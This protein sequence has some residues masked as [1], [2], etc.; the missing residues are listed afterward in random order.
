[1][2]SP[3][4]SRGQI[5]SHF[6]WT[7]DYLHWGIKWS[8]VQRMLIDAPRYEYDSKEKEKKGKSLFSMTPSQIK[9]MGG[10]FEG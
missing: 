7:W 9:K 1:L 6:G 4:G 3:Y 10:K 8:I 2:N 5:L